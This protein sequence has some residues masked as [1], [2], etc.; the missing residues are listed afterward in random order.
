[1]RVLG[2]HLLAP[3]SQVIK[4]YTHFAKDSESILKVSGVA[5]ASGRVSSIEGQD[6]N[7]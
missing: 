2:L 1:M 5:A 6:K 7:I 3:F 4:V